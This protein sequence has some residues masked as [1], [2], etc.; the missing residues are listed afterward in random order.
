MTVLK[1]PV[2]M[3]TKNIDLLHHEVSDHITADAVAQRNYWDGKKGCFI[4][5][6]A[7]S[8]QTRIIEELY[9]LPVAVLRI[10]ESIFEGLPAPEA[11]TFFAEFPS[12]VSCN[13]KDLS[14]VHWKFLASELESLPPQPGKIQTI[15]DQVIAGVNLLAVGNVWPAE[16]LKT[17]QTAALVA[18]NSF[19]I[20]CV[21]LNYVTSGA[22]ATKAALYVTTA[23]LEA[24]QLI[25]TNPYKG[26]AAEVVAFETADATFELSKA[27]NT[28]CYRQKELLLSLIREAPVVKLT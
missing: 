12:A 5:C 10:A 19:Y 4:G 21:A 27:N 14:W 8:R 1:Q 6:L 23:A 26:T 20:E 3:L 16:E 9:G 7:H 17:T 11:K 22:C 24:Q 15:L 25:T 2:L 18:A 13:N 28:V